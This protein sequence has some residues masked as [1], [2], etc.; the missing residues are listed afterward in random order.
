MSEAQR[1]A[2]DLGMKIS[3]C[4]KMLAWL[5]DSS[6][7]AAFPSRVAQA[8]MGYGLLDG[9]CEIIV[10]EV[11]HI[12]PSMRYTVTLNY[13]RKTVMQANG[14]DIAELAKGMARSVAENLGEQVMSVF[15]EEATP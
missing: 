10:K 8:P 15:A 4:L 14:P 1:K 6:R 2:H 9:D 11:K 5:Y 3:K 13:W 12:G 7:D